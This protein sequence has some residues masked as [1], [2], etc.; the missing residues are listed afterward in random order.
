M[1]RLAAEFYFE[2][3][4][5]VVS[6]EIPGLSVRFHRGR[7]DCEIWS[8]IAADK[9]PTN[10][11]FDKLLVSVGLQMGTLPVIRV[12]LRFDSDL[13][14][15]TS[16]ANEAKA[17]EEGLAALELAFKEASAALSEFIWWTRIRKGQVWLNAHPD[18]F[19]LFQPGRLL[20]EDLD[21]ALPVE[22]SRPGPLPTVPAK[23][24][25]DREFF[26]T[27]SGLLGD[28]RPDLPPAESLYADAQQLASE[29]PPDL[30]KAVLI[31]AI[32]CEAKVKET[33]RKCPR[34]ELL[35]M[36]DLFLNHPRDFT[37]AAL[38]LFTDVMMVVM[39]RSLKKENAGLSKRIGK[40]FEHRNAIAHSK[41]QAPSDNQL[42]DAV[43]AAKLAL[44]WLDQVQR[45]AT[46]PAP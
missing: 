32:A 31:A 35:P 36:V 16:E 42:R 25:I 29:E 12:T 21:Q 20:D 44:E 3:N 23:G 2:L 13:S 15:A 39:G 10:G 28:G 33:L 34:A 14:A 41:N 26:E 6:P 8:P 37:V 1:P 4:N 17:K 11:E 38:C 24:A 22:L 46:P 5:V 9:L 19:R 45:S 18:S 30:K 43:E 40:L 27:I 7:F